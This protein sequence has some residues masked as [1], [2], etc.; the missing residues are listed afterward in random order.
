M[1]LLEL[2]NKTTVEL[3]KMYAE[4]CDRRFDLQFKVASKQLK[5]VREIRDVKKTMARINT[6]LKQRDNK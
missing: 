1:K 2:K 4:I 5:N 6:I 3:Q